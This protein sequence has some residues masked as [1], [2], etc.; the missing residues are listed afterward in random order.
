MKSAGGY[1]RWFIFCWVV[2]GFIAGCGGGGSSSSNNDAP[3]IAVPAAQVG[4]EG[5]TLSFSVTGTDANSGDTLSYQLS[6]A[7]EG[8][9]IDSAT[10]AFTWT[11]TFDQVGVHVFVFSVS[12]AVASDSAEVQVTIQVDPARHASLPLAGGTLDPLSIP[13]FVT[14]LVIPPVMST[15]GTADKYDIAVRQFQQQILPG[16]IWNT[17]NGRHDKFPPTT[18]WSYGPTADPAPDSSAL[19]GGAGIAPADNS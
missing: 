4:V 18:V 5:S 7:P 11:P 13:K 2:T 9:S 19:G 8:A 3:T 16:G 17:I 10:G 15:T 1:L 6:G 12:D 14:P